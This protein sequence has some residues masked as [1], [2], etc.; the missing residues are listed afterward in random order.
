MITLALVNQTVLDGEKLVRYTRVY[1][2]GTAGNMYEGGDVYNYI[3][4]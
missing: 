3:G 1:I 2:V 4:V